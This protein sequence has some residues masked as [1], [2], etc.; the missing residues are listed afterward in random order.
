MATRPGNASKGKAQAPPPPES[1]NEEG[2]SPG[3]ETLD[4]RTQLTAL[5]QTQAKHT[6]DAADTK[7]AIENIQN[8]LAQLISER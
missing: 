1:H 7:A 8:L 3:S 4:L 5:R 2:D 6:T